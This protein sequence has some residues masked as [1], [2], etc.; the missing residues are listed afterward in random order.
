[1][2]NIKK[3]NRIAK[4]CKDNEIETVKEV[5][6]DEEAETKDNKIDSVAIKIANEE[7]TVKFTNRRVSRER[8]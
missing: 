4:P 6:N 5:G 1:M 7:F 3:K 2:L 8:K